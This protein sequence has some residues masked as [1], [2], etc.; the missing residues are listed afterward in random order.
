MNKHDFEIKGYII[1]IKYH[2]KSK[3]E[4]YWTN[5]STHYNNKIYSNKEIAKQAEEETLKSLPSSKSRITPI[6]VIKYRKE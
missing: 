2:Y 3:D 4:D 6:Y 1:E 5:W